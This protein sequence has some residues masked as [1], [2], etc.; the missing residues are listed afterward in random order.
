MAVDFIEKQRLLLIKMDSQG[1]GPSRFGFWEH[2]WGCISIDQFF[3]II[4]IHQGS[5]LF[6][7]VSYKV[8]MVTN[9]CFHVHLEGDVT[10][11][12]YRWP[13]RAVYV[14]LMDCETL[15]HTALWYVLV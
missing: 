13:V 8:V 9:K 3:H 7:S 4:S 14:Y 2:I 6:F 12:T 15:R 1:R 11:E 5:A 10:V